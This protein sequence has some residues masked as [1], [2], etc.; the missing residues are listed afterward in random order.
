VKYLCDSNVWLALALGQHTH[1]GAASAWFGALGETEIAFFCRSTRISFLRL[2]TQHLAP[3]FQS[4]TNRQAWGVLD[5]LLED[6][7]VGFA[8]EPPDMDGVWRSLS[9]ENAASPKKW[10]DAYLAAFAMAGG[11]RLVTFDSGFRSFEPGGLD[12]LLLGS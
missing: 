6:E 7:A 2:L 5:Q 4:L 9:D 1:H 3:G 12:L 8:A 10:M 11:L